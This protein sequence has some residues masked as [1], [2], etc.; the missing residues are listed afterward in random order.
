[1]K[2]YCA[3]DVSFMPQLR[4]AYRKKLCD[5]WWLKIEAETTERIRLSQ[6]PGYNGKGR[7]MALGP[8]GWLSWNSSPSERNVRTLLQ[9]NPARGTARETSTLPKDLIPDAARRTEIDE[10][11]EPGGSWT[12]AAHDVGGESHAF[13]AHTMLA[14]ALRRSVLDVDDEE[15]FEEEEQQYF[16]GGYDDYDGPSFDSDRGG[17][18]FTA[19]SKDDCGYCGRCMY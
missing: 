8:I 4:Q 14:D 5:A 12:A 1:M 17:D 9:D 6:S 10:V 13:G 11:A 7:H 3:Q 2:R 15:D 16:G 18:D 19:C